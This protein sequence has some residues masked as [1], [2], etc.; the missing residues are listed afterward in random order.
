MA[1]L[2]NRNGVFYATFSDSARKPRQ[3]RLSLG[4]RQRRTAERLL[5]RLDEAYALATWDPWTGTPDDVLAPVR[6]EA[7]KKVGEAAALYMDHVRETF[8]PTTIRTRRTLIAR[9]V[10]HVG[11]SLYAER[12]TAGHVSAFMKAN[13]A[14][15]STQNHR[16]IA[17]KSFGTFCLAHGMMTESPAHTVPT[18]KTPARL[19]R[20]VTDEELAAVLEAIPDGRAWTRS[21]FKFAA[22]TGLRAGELA[23]LRWTDVD[24]ERRLLRIET[25]KNGKAQTQPMPRAALAVLATAPR[26]GDYVFTSPLERSDVRNVD[27]FKNLLD[28]AFRAGRE[29]AGIGRKITPHGLRHRYC[30]KIAESGAN[31]FTIAAA[32]RHADVK[33]SQRYVNISNQRLRSELDSVFG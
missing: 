9:F 20:A 2:H 11:P 3:R 12:L 25:Q 22:L 1:S 33:T 21:V 8:S 29:A 17:L 26:R 10:A 27:T 30:T 16:L 14:A 24:D 18:P 32:A 13:G 5:A 7:P 15:P 19:P 4:T 28:E 31:A 23:R 6:V